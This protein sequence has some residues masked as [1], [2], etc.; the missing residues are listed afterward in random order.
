MK[1]KTD[2]LLELLKYLFIVLIVCILC[3][4]FLK[5]QQMNIEKSRLTKQILIDYNKAKK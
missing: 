5:Y 4:T 1:T 3:N 2:A